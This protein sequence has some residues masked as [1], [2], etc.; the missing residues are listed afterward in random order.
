MPFPL[1]PIATAGVNRDCTSKLQLIATAAAGD[2]DFCSKIVDLVSRNGKLHS[3]DCYLRDRALTDEFLYC[4]SQHQAS[5]S[6]ADGFQSSC[7]DASSAESAQGDHA[8]HGGAAA[9]TVC[10]DAHAA[11]DDAAD[12]EDVRSDGDSS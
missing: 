10:H 11:A 9:A 7:H 8:Q 12:G 2:F 5:T 3:S 6:R 4:C 1:Q